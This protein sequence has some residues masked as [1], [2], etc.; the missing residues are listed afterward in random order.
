MSALIETEALSKIYPS[1][2]ALDRCTLRVN[3]GE[4]FGLL[5]PNGAGKTT[6]LRLL[7][8]FLRPTSGSARISNL[9]CYRERVAVHR[10]L[11]Y[12]PGDAR[13][14]RTMR[15]R[16]VIRFFS[17]IRKNASFQRGLD[18]A[19]RLDLDLSRFVGFMSTGMRQKLALAACFSAETPLIILDEPTA[20]LDPNVRGEVLKMVMEA[21][22]RGATVVFSSHVLSEVEETC[23]EVAILR[24]GQLVHQQSLHSL[25]R[26][27]R[28][29][30]KVHGEL[31][32]FPNG[33]AQQIEI[34]Q[35][36]T[37]NLSTGIP[38]DLSL[39]IPGELSPVLK[40]LADQPLDDV[41]VSPIGLRAVYDRFHSAEPEIEE[42]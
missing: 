12:L 1:V 22:Q 24:A 30:A 13:L 40:W 6:L 15:G 42:V 2:T 31:T 33:L 3:Q 5:G 29:R 25:K 36:L 7:L 41:L 35:T 34:A 27:H 32:P 9:D 10:E 4:V 20:N 23:D 11:V 8:G 19:D 28:V 16:Q 17:Q 38:G 14:F 37:G 21:K 39:E 18:V 26:H